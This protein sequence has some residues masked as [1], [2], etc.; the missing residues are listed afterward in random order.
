MAE[1]R[2][3]AVRTFRSSLASLSSKPLEGRG[4][5]EER[6]IATNETDEGRERNRRAEIVV[7]PVVGP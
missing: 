1:A 5:G 7:T 2:A 3:S 4:D 6:P